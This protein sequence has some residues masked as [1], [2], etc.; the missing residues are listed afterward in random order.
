M[1]KSNAWIVRNFL[2]GKEI[3][4]MECEFTIY[5]NKR[6]KRLSISVEALIALLKL[7]HPQQLTLRVCKN[8]DLETFT[9]LAP[10]LDSMFYI[11]FLNRIL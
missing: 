6:N 4:C 8:C 7:L 2:N 1:S 10:Q 3:F 9:R 5:L 11:V